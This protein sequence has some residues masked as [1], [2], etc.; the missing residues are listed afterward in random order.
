LAQASF[1]PNL[2]L[3]KY[4]SSLIPVILL[5][6][7]TYED[8]TEYSETL[9]HKIQMLGNHPK[10]IIYHTASCFVYRMLDKIT[11]L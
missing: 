10:E 9:A 8:G 11:V 3:Y 2:H 5:V 7:T 4:P 1:E 6:H